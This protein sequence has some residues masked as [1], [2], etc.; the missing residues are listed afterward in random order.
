[1]SYGVGHRC[2]LDMALL[3]LWHRLAA[4]API[5]PQAWECIH[6]AGVALKK[7]KYKK[8][9]KQMNAA[10]QKQT[11]SHREK[12]SGCQRGERWEGVKKVKRI[13]YKLPIIK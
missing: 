12:I 8:K 5:C 2:G 13:K 9:A 3:W 1:M 10:K 11:H 6:A 7:I 4:T